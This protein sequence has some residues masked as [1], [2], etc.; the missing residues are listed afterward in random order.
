MS[1]IC[2]WPNGNYCWPEYLE[3]MKHL[4]TNYVMVPVAVTEYSWQAAERYKQTNQTNGGSYAI[5]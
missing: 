3:E 4:G 2:V 5:P 1:Q